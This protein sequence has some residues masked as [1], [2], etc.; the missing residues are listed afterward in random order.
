MLHISPT[1]CSE[2]GLDLPLFCFVIKARTL[3][4]SE[5]SPII[6]ARQEIFSVK[7][8]GGISA[9]HLATQEWFLRLSVFTIV[10]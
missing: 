5:Y 1:N 9:E 10:P 3:P 8:E 2:T 4:E 6:I 7:R